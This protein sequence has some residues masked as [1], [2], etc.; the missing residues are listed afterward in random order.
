[1]GDFLSIFEVGVLRLTP[2]CGDRNILVSTLHFGK[3]IICAADVDLRAEQFSGVL[4]L[5]RPRF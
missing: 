5:R 1:M 2:N 3:Q 4:R